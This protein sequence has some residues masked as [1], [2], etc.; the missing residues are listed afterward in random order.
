MLEKL[1][2]L[3]IK[4]KKHKNKC[5]DKECFCNDEKFIKT[6]NFTVNNHKNDLS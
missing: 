5:F 3:K 4:G 1:I 2:E 6:I